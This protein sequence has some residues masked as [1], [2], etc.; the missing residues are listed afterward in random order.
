VAVD[1]QEN[2]LIVQSKILQNEVYLVEGDSAGGTAKQGRDR[3]CNF[4]YVVKFE[5]GKSNAP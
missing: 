1:C 4:H 2:Y 3:A 5:R